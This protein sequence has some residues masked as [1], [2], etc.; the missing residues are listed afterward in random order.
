MIEKADIRLS[1]EKKNELRQDRDTNDR[2][3]RV[4][5]YTFYL[6]VIGT[7]VLPSVDLVEGI[8]FHQALSTTLLP[9]ACGSSMMAQGYYSRKSRYNKE[10]EGRD[11][12][13]SETL[14]NQE[15][16]QRAKKRS[17][18]YLGLAA[19]GGPFLHNLA[20]N[21]EHL[22][23]SI[24][25][26]EVAGI[27]ACATALYNVCAKAGRYAAIKEHVKAFKE[28]LKSMATINGDGYAHIEGEPVSSPH[29]SSQGTQSATI[30]S[31]EDEGMKPSTSNG[32]SLLPANIS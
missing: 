13:F 4:A 28:Q 6:S 10:F 16:A 32:R 17:Y 21:S 2:F 31:E 20:E 5:N 30:L 14:D 19:A 27:F 26:L 3:E 9:L 12:S 25:A 29:V 1:S 24:G 23:E 8:Q 22:V 11:S 7:L 15:E 18:G